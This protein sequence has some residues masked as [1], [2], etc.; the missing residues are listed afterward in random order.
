MDLLQDRREKSLERLSVLRSTLDR[1]EKLAGDKACVYVTGSFGRLEASEHSDLDVFIA[2]R[3]GEGGGGLRRLDEIRI[4]AALIDATE[5]QNFP[6]FSGD[7]RFLQSYA[8]QTLVDAIGA[9]DDDAQNTLTARLLL[10]L[11]SRCLIGQNVY[12][13]VI[14]SVVQAYWRDYDGHEDAFTPAFLINDI[15]RLW[16]T[17]CVNY[18]ANTRREPADERLDAKIKNYKLRFSRMLTCHSAVLHLLAI[19]A[20]DG[21][22]RP[23]DALAMSRLTPTDRLIATRMLLP[24]TARSVVDR[25]LDLYIAFLRITAVPKQDL[26]ATFADKARENAMRAEAEAFGDAMAEAILALRPVTRLARLVVV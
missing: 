1:A 6:S 21:A 12:E 16:R 2:T 7:G 9:Q 23:E 5:S 13:H 18:E 25:M 10:L 17:F 11:K 4:K 20:R 24:E 26:R 19:H 3:P 15:L 22:V 14:D 8:E